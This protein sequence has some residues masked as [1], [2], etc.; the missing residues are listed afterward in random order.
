MNPNNRSFK[1][2]FWLSTEEKDK[3]EILFD[4]FRDELIK[5]FPSIDIE[6]IYAHLAEK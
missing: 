4:Y 3:I 6:D 5:A 1:M 2:T